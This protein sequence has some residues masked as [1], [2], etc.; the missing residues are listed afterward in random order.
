MT[1]TE[2]KKLRE[3]KWQLADN[4]VLEEEKMYMLRDTGL[5]TEII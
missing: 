4:W 5:R 3:D 2:V 1:R